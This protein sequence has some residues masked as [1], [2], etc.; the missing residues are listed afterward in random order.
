M[1]YDPTYRKLFISLNVTF[2]E[3]V[4]VNFI[5]KG[6]LMVAMMSPHV[7]SHLMYL[8]LVVMLVM[9]EKQ[10]DVMLKGR[11]IVTT[12]MSQIKLQLKG[13]KRWHFKK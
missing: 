7:W 2:F 6:G 8:I 3:S 4:P 13:E 1:C 12:H 9:K 10:M 5:L 11:M